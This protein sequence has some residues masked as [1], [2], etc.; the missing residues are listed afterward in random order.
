[1]IPT[2]HKAKLPRTLSYPIGA[3][4]ISAALAGTPHAESLSLAFRDQAIWPASEFHRLI[5]ERL[6]YRIFAAEYRPAQ[7]PGYGGNRRMLEDGWFDQKWE[8]RVYAVPREL[9]PLASRLLRER[10]LPAVADW[11][12]S[13]RRLGWEDHWQCI[14]L[15]F[16]PADGTLTPQDKSGV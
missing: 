2:R 15:V 13:S 1:M 7:K 14:E 4:A 10:G 8:L 6:P 16:S 3:E 5:R 11:L 12:Q 9:R